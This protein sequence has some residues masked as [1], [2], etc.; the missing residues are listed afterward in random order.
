[1]SISLFAA[2]YGAGLVS[3]VSPCVL[4]LLP[5]YLVVLAGADLAPGRRPWRAGLG[6]VVGL[7]LVFVALGAGASVLAATLSAYR[8]ALMIGVGALMVL[9]GAKLLGVLRVSL[10]D[11]EARPLLSRVPSP[12]GFWGGLLFGAAF[13]LGWTPCVGPVLGATLSYAA[14]H[15]ASPA[16]AAAQL[17]VYALGLSTPLFVAT[18]A[19]ERVL[20][21]A[22][23]LRGVMVNVQRLSGALLIGLGLLIATD[24]LATLSAPLASTTESPAACDVEGSS[25]CSIDE[26]AVEV[27]AVATVPLGRP[28]L[29]EFV[30]E[31]CTVCARMAPLVAKLEQTCTDGDGSIVRV[32]IDSAE[33]RALARRFNVRAVPTFLQ[34]DAEG[35][36]VERVI[37]EQTPEQLALALQNVRGA[38]CQ[39]M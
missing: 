21:L 10:L 38:A 22:R 16:H 25:S 13:S 18:F 33:G 32:G 12:G 37:G 24:R 31:H 23:R 29:L 35:A 26:G 3:F 2:L 11:S 36:E 27:D 5:S 4:P 19:A 39:L 7:S 34:L 9:F 6:F 20:K 17:A 30:S 15:S 28:H 14:S 8:Q 1:M